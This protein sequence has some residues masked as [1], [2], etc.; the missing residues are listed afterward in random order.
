MKKTIVLLC[1]LYLILAYGT[2]LGESP[3]AAALS[4]IKATLVDIKAALNNIPPA[5]SKKLPC[6]STSN[7][8]RFELVLDGAAVLD[9]ETG[10]V[11]EK[12]PHTNTSIW[13]DSSNLCSWFDCFNYCHELSTGNR[14]G[15]RLPMIQE[16]ASLGER[17]GGSLSLP[18]GHPFIFEQFNVAFF[19]SSYNDAFNFNNSWAVS[20]GNGYMT[21]AWKEN[22]Y[23]A[24]C[25][26]GG[27]G[28]NPQ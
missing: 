23:N 22:R 21:Y 1:A 2:A 20:F 13:V 18:A 8:P 16:L 10:L 7:C 25:V 14:F 11:W 26:R 9:K 27:Q 28:V 5:W 3:T 17:T 15:W 6:D 4:D 19:W 24:W 12:S